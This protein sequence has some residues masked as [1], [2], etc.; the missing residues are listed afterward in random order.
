MRGIIPR[1]TSRR[2]G[3]VTGNGPK[4]G[5]SGFSGTL[6]PLNLP[7]QPLLRVVGT[8]LAA[9][10]QVRPIVIK[11]ISFSWTKTSARSRPQQI[12]SLQEGDIQLSEKWFILKK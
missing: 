11:T 4:R 10:V 6:L 1:G 9:G 5:S 8:V 12:G 3:T 2:T 7:Q